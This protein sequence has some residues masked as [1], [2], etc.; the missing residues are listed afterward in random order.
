LP[1]LQWM[2]L[3]PQPATPVPLFLQ[4]PPRVSGQLPFRHMSPSVLGGQHRAPHIGVAQQPPLV[5]SH[6]AASLQ[7]CPMHMVAVHVERPAHAGEADRMVG[8]VHATP[9]TTAVRAR[10]R[11]R[12]KVEG[13]ASST[14]AAERFA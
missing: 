11:R 13:P 4:K 8:A 12:L 14:R 6:G 2:V 10:K 9:P 5:V 1:L 7:H 3:F